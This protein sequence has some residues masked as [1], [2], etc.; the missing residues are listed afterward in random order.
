VDPQEFDSREEAAAERRFFAPSDAPVELDMPAGDPVRAATS[1][2]AGARHA[3]RAKFGRIVGGVVGVAVVMCGV[4]TLRGRTSLAATGAT[5]A[6]SASQSEKVRSESRVPHVP[7]PIES[8]PP[9]LSPDEQDPD[10][11]T[12]PPPPDARAGLRAA[13][14][15]RARLEAGRVKEAI[16]LG[17][18]AVALA[19]DEAFAWLVLGAAYEQ[20]GDLTSARRAYATCASRG[21][22]GLHGPADECAALLRR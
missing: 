9:A 12:L 20:S 15:A 1:L 5:H 10:A 21:A 6:T 16:A 11:L 14:D 2:S 17:Q 8:D 18:G 3:W 4:A 19:P 22:H 13:E 7:Y